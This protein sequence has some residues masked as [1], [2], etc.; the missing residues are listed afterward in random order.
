[1]HTVTLLKVSALKG[2]S[3]GSTDIFCEQAQQNT[4]PDVN[5]RLESSAGCS[6]IF[7]LICNIRVGL[8]LRL[9]LSRILQN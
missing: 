3:S 5:I 2:Q 9:N 6:L 7:I 1:M 8:A 4:C